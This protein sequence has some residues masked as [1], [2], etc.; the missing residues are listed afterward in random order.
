M[1]N[2]SNIPATGVIGRCLRSVLKLI[3]QGSVVGVRAGLNKGM[4]WV[5]HSSTHGCW[6]GTYEMDKQAAIRRLVQPGMT[7][8]DIGANAGFYTMAF[9]R[10]VGDRGNVYAFE[11]YAE[12]AANILTHIALNHTGNVTLIQAAV[13]DHPGTVGFNVAQSN[14]MGAIAD[15]SRYLIPSVT[16]DHLVTNK[17]V[18]VPDLIKMDV[19]GAEGR[20]LAGAQALLQERKTIWL[21]ALHGEGQK[22]QCQ[23]ILVSANYRIY[24]L[25][26]TELTERLLPTDEI[27]ALPAAP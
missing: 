19:E 18:P 14:A 20:V 26:G 16:L 10:L 11:P 23:Q 24:A 27:Y 12:N 22:K 25:D 7:V 9:S 6:L 5:A 13:A 1:I 4:R 8:F 17:I 3:P 21:I 2:W 15:D